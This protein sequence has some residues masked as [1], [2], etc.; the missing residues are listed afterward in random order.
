MMD[1]YGFVQ[2]LLIFRANADEAVS[3][4][5]DRF[6][7]PLAFED[8]YG[9]VTAVVY[10]TETFA[11]LVRKNDGYYLFIKSSTD[12]VDNKVQIDVFNYR[13]MSP[14]RMIDHNANPS[15]ILLD[16][17]GLVKAVAIKG[18][19]VFTDATR[20][21]VNILQAANSLAGLKE[22]TEPAE[23]GTISQFS[24]AA[25]HKQ[26]RYRPIKTGGQQSSAKAICPI[27]L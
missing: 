15:S 9:A 18:N 7:S 8:P 17:L 22:F 20:T 19:G 24:G 2:D 26:Y 25:P 13:T 1:F 12:E 27:C 6:F 3:N 5:K 4:V 16:E 14:A 23:T 10:D 11:N 21:A